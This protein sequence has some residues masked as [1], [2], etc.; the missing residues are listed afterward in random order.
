MVLPLK[1]PPLR[2]TCDDTPDQAGLREEESMGSSSRGGG[3]RDRLTPR[4]MALPLL[5][6]T[7]ANGQSF[8]VD[9]G[10]GGGLPP[11]DPCHSGRGGMRRASVNPR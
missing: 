5:L 1:L 6:C 3:H 2:A 8:E 10:Y 11:R 7:S 9:L 4:V